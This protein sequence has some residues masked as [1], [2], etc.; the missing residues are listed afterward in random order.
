MQPIT[1]TKSNFEAEV[2]KSEKPVLL[3]FWAPWCGP[4]QMIAPILDEIAKEVDYA[5]IGKI[6]VDEE[7]ELAAAFGA[8]S[9]PLLAVVKDGVLVNQILGA[10]PKE[11]MLELIAPYKSS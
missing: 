2:T 10:V 4:C 5:K 3:D 7:P 6:N 11:K 9:I 8:M 1:I